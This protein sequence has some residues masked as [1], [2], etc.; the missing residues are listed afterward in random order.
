MSRS[1]AEACSCHTDYTTAIVAWLLG[2]RRCDPHRS[3]SRTSPTRSEGKNHDTCFKKSKMIYKT[4]N[5]TADYI[6]YLTST[7]LISETDN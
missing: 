1:E 4:L 3:V 2:R 5:W 6:F 7:E